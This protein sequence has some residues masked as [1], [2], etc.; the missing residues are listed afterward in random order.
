MINCVSSLD[1][2]TSETK[3]H[4]KAARL[5]SRSYVVNT[6]AV[7]RKDQSIEILLRNPTKEVSVLA[8]STANNSTTNH[9][10]THSV[11]VILVFK[12]VLMEFLCVSVFAVC[13]PE[14]CLCFMYVNSKPLKRRF[15]RDIYQLMHKTQ[16]RNIQTHT[17]VYIPRHFRN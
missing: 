17:C 8:S 12:I 13:Y 2:L 11:H 1:V 16:N 15:T 3:K 6:Q 4:G 5:T 10:S 14:S 7:L 9:R